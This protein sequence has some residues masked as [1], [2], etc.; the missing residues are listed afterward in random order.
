MTGTASTARTRPTVRY[1][2]HVS[3]RVDD[4]E[5]SLE[6]YVG[7]LGCTRLE[8]PDLGFPGAWLQLDNVQVHLLEVPSDESLGAPPQI[9]SPLANHVAFSVA[10]VEG[11]RTFLQQ[12]GL[13]PIDGP[14][15]L[16]P[17][18]VVQDPSGNVVEFTPFER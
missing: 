11:F 5:T 16:V 1:L 4:L 9:V 3:F 12:K 17:Q 7:V 2:H 8:R 10:D 15:P 6:F 14:N 18:L 13:S